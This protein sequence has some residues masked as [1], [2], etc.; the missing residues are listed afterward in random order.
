MLKFKIFFLFLFLLFSLFVFS[1]ELPQEI[2]FQLSWEKDFE[3]ILELNNIPTKGEILREKE[4]ESLEKEKRELLDKKERLE[5]K[6]QILSNPILT[7]E[8]YD[9]MLEEGTRDVSST[10]EIIKEKLDIVNEKID[11]INNKLRKMNVRK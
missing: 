1:Q 5:K 11:E 10:I 7:D 3:L 2:V 9:Q 4:I 8:L 6:L